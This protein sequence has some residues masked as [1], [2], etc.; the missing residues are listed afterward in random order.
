MKLTPAQSQI[1]KDR[2]RFRVL[3]CG[4]RFGKTV[5][6]VEEM[7][8]VAI[9]EK[10]RRVAYYAP[11]RDDA[12]EI[13]WSMLKKKCENI[14]TSANESL[15]ELKILTLDG[16]E[17]LIALY[18]WE[19]VQE[20]GKGRGLA[21]DFIVCDEVATYRNFW[22]GW[23][24]V[25]SPTLVDRKGSAMF[26]STPKGFNHFY[27]L[28]NLELT[29][30]D[31]KSFHFTTYDNP[32]LPPEEIEREKNSKPA[33]TFAQEYL[34]DFKKKQGLVY[35]EFSR[36]K[37]LYEEEFEPH[38][39]KTFRYVAGVDFGYRNPAAVL[40]C[41]WTGERLLIHNEWYKKERTDVQIAEYVASAKFRE[42]YPDPENQSGIEEMR[43]LGV[44]VHEVVKGKDSVRAGIQSVREMLIR[45][46]I[47][48]HKRCVNL[49]SE[50]ESYSYDDDVVEKNEQENPIKLNDHALDALR[51]VVATLLP[52]IQRNTIIQNMP[53]I[54]RVE[55][56]NP[57]I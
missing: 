31:F 14:T 4:R 27:D 20:R 32:H 21:N 35:K 23:N 9:K 38:I 7:V 48:I 34:A 46:D 41:L 26:I 40:H 18:G 28:Y 36:E 52:V 16:G 3:N 50:F 11:T 55:K 44:N 10:D 17:S 13:A 39:L 12:R 2:H 33:D 6:A 47:M 29:D 51:Y 49:I 8:G 53:R 5:L 54:H 56:P 43:R 24:E 1:A 22:V 30:H 15:L 45:G 19:S 57:A 25:L 42:V 37:H